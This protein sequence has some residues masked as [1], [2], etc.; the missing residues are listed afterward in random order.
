MLPRAVHFTVTLSE[1]KM[2]EAEEQGLEKKFKLTSSIRYMV[3]FHW[4]NVNSSLWPAAIWNP[5]PLYE[6]ECPE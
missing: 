6:P 1:D 2:R 3:G 4:V 5:L